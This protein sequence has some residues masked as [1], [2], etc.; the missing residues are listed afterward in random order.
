MMRT[1]T[2][3]G[4][5]RMQLFARAGKLQNALSDLS[6]HASS[7]TAAVGD[8][9]GINRGAWARATA[10]FR[11]AMAELARALRSRE[12]SALA[13][14]RAFLIRFLAAPAGSEGPNRRSVVALE[15]LGAIFAS[16]SSLPVLA[17]GSFAALVRPDTGKL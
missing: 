2:V 8:D 5:V 3:P 13:L 6:L 9:V 15:A 10:E 12:L 1:A 16:E 11:R 4:H 7:S 14:A 17:D